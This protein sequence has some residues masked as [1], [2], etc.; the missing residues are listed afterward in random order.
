VSGTPTLKEASMKR[1]PQEVFQ[2]HAEALIAGKIDDIVADYADDAVFITPSGV[3][4]GK[5][6]I[7]QAFTDLLSDL[8]NAE[9]AVP[10][11]IFEGNVLFIEWTADSADTRADDGIDTFVFGKDGEIEVQTVRYTLQRKS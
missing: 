6:G 8:P 10:T 7:R 3:L 9:W 5:D 1:T 2:H 4:R 11:Q